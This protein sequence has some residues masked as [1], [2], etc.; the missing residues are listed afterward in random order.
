[1]LDD[2]GNEI[3]IGVSD[4]ERAK[5]RAVLDKTTGKD[6]KKKW[7]EKDR[8][9]LARAEAA[10]APPAI[11]EP[12]CHVCNSEYRVWIERCLVKGYAYKRIADQ[13][14][15]D[16]DGNKPD[17]RSISNHA[18]HHMEIA[19]GV[20]RAELEEEADL[21]KQNYEEG[22]KGALTIRGMLNVIARRAYDDYLNGQITAEIKDLIQLV[23]VLN[24]MNA[25][26]NT[27]KVEET[28]IAL[29]IIVQAVQN[30]CSTEVQAE[31]GAEVKRLQLQ[32]D[33]QYQIEAHFEEPVIVDAEVVHEKTHSQS[34]G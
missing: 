11:T 24:E 1:M 26:V 16:P 28:E 21:L 31:I 25:D 23:K 19:H 30:I 27:V 8:E 14:P 7:D 13:L 33:V 32:D 18:K 22:V 9:E 12:R 15:P 5:R 6:L 17:R 10:I 2:T 20:V 3:E 4:A 34:N 29:R